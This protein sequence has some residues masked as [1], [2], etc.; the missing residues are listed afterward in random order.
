MFSFLSK[1][2]SESPKKETDKQQKPTVVAATAE[3]EEVTDK[4]VKVVDTT[5][6]AVTTSKGTDKAEAT[7][8]TVAEHAAKTVEEEKA[9]QEPKAKSEAAKSNDVVKPT[10]VKEAEKSTDVPK[11]DDSSEVKKDEKATEEPKKEEKATEQPKKEEKATEVKSPAKSS[12]GKKNKK[13]KKSAETSPSKSDEELEK[14]NKELKQKIEDLT[15]KYEQQHAE[16]SQKKSEQKQLVG[17]IAQLYQLTLGIDGTATSESPKQQGK[18]SSPKVGASKKER[19]VAKQQQKSSSSSSSPI[20]EKQQHAAASS[21]SSNNRN[22]AG[23]VNR[24]AQEQ[25]LQQLIAEAKAHQAQLKKKQSSNG[26][27]SSTTEPDAESVRARLRSATTKKDIEDAI[28]DAKKLNMTYEASLG[29]EAT[30]QRIFCPEQI[31]IPQQLHE[32][33]KDMT[34]E[35]V[36]WFGEGDNGVDNTVESSWKVEGKSGYWLSWRDSKQELLGQLLEGN[37]HVENVI[38]KPDVAKLAREDEL[39]EQIEAL[40]SGQDRHVEE[41][42]GNGGESEG[43]SSTAKGDSEV[44]TGEGG[45]T[46]RSKIKSIKKKLH[47]IDKLVEAAEG[48]KALT[49]QQKQKISR[50]P[51]LETELSILHS[52]AA[53]SVTVKDTPAAT[54]E[55]PKMDNKVIAANEGNDEDE[56]GGE[57]IPSDPKLRRA[58]KRKTSFEIGRSTLSEKVCRVIRQPPDGSC[59]FHALGYWL[60]KPQHIIRKQISGFLRHNASTVK[61]NGLTLE[62]WIKVESNSRTL[63]H[64]CNNL[65]KDNTWG[66]EIELVATSM[67]YN[68]DV[69]VW[70]HENAPKSQTGKYVLC[71]KFHAPPVSE[72][73]TTN[74]YAGRDDRREAEEEPITCHVLFDGKK[75]YNVLVLDEKY[76]LL[77]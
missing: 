68:C 54:V 11:A 73:Y 12:S 66:G 2:T 19:K 32:V 6:V 3:T 39:L 77:K 5:S 49:E 13:G 14:E 46:R 45:Q 60:N 17:V 22:I 57:W 27:E 51:E 52:A 38:D 65:L 36:V 7:Q 34:K 35:V 74:R 40:E 47:D 61:L 1:L 70:Q 41:A 59:L 25:G 30:G 23:F 53:A 8:T 26:T 56:D 16:F 24:P 10:V 9:Q 75:H 76:C 67:L 43:C 71:Y 21:T 42:N 62:E 50:R 48:G 63:S 58:R 28:S 69:Y 33:L 55:G 31:E 37:E 18:N 15:Q 20:A 64:Y 44:A 72:K 29:V 4:S